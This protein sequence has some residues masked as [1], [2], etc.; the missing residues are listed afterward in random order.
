MTTR[1]TISHHARPAVRRCGSLFVL[2]QRLAPGLAQRLAP[3]LALGVALL[4]TAG[5]END[6]SAGDPQDAGV[7]AAADA[8]LPDAAPDAQ[9]D[10][11]AD[12]TDGA[13]PSTWTVELDEPMA[14]EQ[15]DHVP[16][17][18]TRLSA[19]ASGAL[20][21]AYH[22][23]VD[24]ACQYL[25]LAI[26]HRPPQDLWSDAT[27]LSAAT[28]TFDLAVDGDGQPVVGFLDMDLWEVR[29]SQ[30]IGF[31]QTGGTYSTQTLDATASSNADQLSMAATTQGVFLAYGN[32]LVINPI[33][34][35]HRSGGVWHH[36][37]PID[38]S[39]PG[40]NRSL[41]TGPQD[42]LWLSYRD[43]DAQKVARYDPSL[44]EW[45]TQGTLD[46]TTELLVN[47]L[48]AA[49]TGE[50]CVGGR[51]DHHLEVS[52]A[53]DPSAGT[54]TPEPVGTHQTFYWT[55]LVEVPEGALVAVYHAWQAQQARVV[56]RD[57]AGTSWQLET[58]YDGPS[59][60]LSAA[61]GPTG[62]LYI[63]FMTCDGTNCWIRVLSRDEPFAT[64]EPRAN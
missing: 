27:A 31:G 33:W 11:D 41:V 45:A 38:G 20:W 17:G 42:D 43:G 64:V 46:P 28:A 26:R 50:V 30:G 13:V 6:K 2:A 9:V 8:R 51:R 44:D 16:Y 57:L 47:G 1:S 35:L 37:T 40:Y 14:A 62:K 61:V 7:D 56:W 10:P 3:G 29:V 52:C 36:V 59:Y 53:T 5:C 63:S 48:V 19:D 21:V 22:E 49:T 58:A 24:L 18:E 15:A 55:P 25:G 23:C 12:T 34:L 54:W 32:Q 39:R 60:G 4:L